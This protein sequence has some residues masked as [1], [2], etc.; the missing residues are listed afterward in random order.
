MFQTVE[1]LEEY[2]SANG[3]VMHDN[4]TSM[5]DPE[6]LVLPCTDSFSILNAQVVE[7]QER[8]HRHYQRNVYLEKV[9]A[10]MLQQALAHRN[11]ISHLEIEMAE[12]QQN[13]HHAGRLG[14]LQHQNDVLTSKLQQM[15]QLLQEAQTNRKTDDEVAALQDTI[16]VLRRRLT[17]AQHVTKRQSISRSYSCND[18]HHAKHAEVLQIPHIKVT[19]LKRVLFS[20]AVKEPKAKVAQPNTEHITRRKRYKVRAGHVMAF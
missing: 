7:V 9:Y 2:L 13:S 15:Q 3:V 17:D 19:P 16:D 8:A 11:K 20:P 18:M 12:M 14:P 6:S 10:T 4:D 1:N 5:E